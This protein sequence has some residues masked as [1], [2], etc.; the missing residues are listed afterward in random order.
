MD[1]LNNIEEDNKDK[2]LL[3]VLIHMQ[4]LTRSQIDEAHAKIKQERSNESILEIL[5]KSGAMGPMMVAMAKAQQF[6]AQ[7]VDVSSIQ[8]SPTLIAYVSAVLAT[9]YRII[10]VGICGDTLSLAMED[11]SD[12]NKIDSLIHLLDKDISV[13][14]TS[15]ENID[16]ALAKYY[17]AA[18]KEVT[19]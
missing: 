14:V 1:T 12:L 18:V 16:A 2:C 6:G 8:I 11:P 13:M 3:E 19:G 4:L 9:K 10:P 7:V 15:S 17:P 5:L